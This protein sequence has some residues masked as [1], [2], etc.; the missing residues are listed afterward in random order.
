MRAVRRCCPSTP[1]VARRKT[2]HSS[3]N[4]PFPELRKVFTGSD[5]DKLPNLRGG[6][7]A[8]AT[9]DAMREPK[10]SAQLQQ[11]SI[12]LLGFYPVDSEEA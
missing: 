7:G 9:A 6:V 10:I 2:P 1:R 3:Y 5:R 8:E 12:V 11:A 4:R